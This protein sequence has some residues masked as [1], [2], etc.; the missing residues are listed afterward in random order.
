MGF[1]VDFVMLGTLKELVR[2]PLPNFSMALAHND[3]NAGLR[4][5]SLASRHHHTILQAPLRSRFVSFFRF[6]RFVSFFR[7]SFCL[8]VRSFVLFVLSVRLFYLFRSFVCFIRLIRL[9]VTFVSFFHSFVV[10]IILKRF[11]ERANV[12]LYVNPS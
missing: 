4:L 7:F 2:G 10:F 8:F 12:F 3:D 6:V 11:C 9:F 1:L 5:P